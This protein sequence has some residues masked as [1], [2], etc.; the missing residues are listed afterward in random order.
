MSILRETHSVMG[1]EY[2][3][4]TTFTG[5]PGVEE[6]GRS[7]L[8]AFVESR[9]ERSKNLIQKAGYEYIRSFLTLAFSRFNPK[10]DIRVSVASMSEYPEISAELRSFYKD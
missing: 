10:P 8:Y 2:L 4:K 3:Q 5:F 9:N 1:I 7:L 6:T